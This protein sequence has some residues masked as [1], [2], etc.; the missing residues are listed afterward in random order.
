MAS[1]DNKLKVLNLLESKEEFT[2]HSYNDTIKSV[3]FSLDGE[4]VI[5]GLKKTKRIC[6]NLMTDLKNTGWNQQKCKGIYL[7]KT[8]NCCYRLCL[9]VFRILFSF[10][11][12]CIH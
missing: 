10:T 8:Q 1:A 2:L 6:V 3:A 7:N 5:V 11:T 4:F 9:Q 12:F